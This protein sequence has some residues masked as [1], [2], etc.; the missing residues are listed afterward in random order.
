MVSSIFFTKYSCTSNVDLGALTKR[1][2]GCKTGSRHLGI[3]LGKIEI[4]EVV[5]DKCGGGGLY[6]PEMQN[7]IL[8]YLH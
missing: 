7:F 6:G 4:D 5:E 1:R 2:L 8:N 3:S